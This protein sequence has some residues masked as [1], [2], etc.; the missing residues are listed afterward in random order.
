MQV[1]VWVNGSFAP[2][3]GLVFELAP[4]SVQGGHFDAFSENMD[5]LFDIV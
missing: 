1:L 5:L 3:N 2:P 4:H